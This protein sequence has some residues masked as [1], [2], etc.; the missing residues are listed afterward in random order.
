MGK[1]NL[2]K[3]FRRAGKPLQK[4]HYGGCTNYPMWRIKSSS[5]P[6]NEGEGALKALIVRNKLKII[7]EHIEI[8]SRQATK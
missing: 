1:K 2:K 5:V 7:G 8:K 6:S 4:L 3:E